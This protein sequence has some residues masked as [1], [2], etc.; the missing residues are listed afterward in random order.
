MGLW[1]WVCITRYWG[2]GPGPKGLW[3]KKGRQNERMAKERSIKRKK[4]TTNE[5]KK[6]QRKKGKINTE[7]KERK[8]E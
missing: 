8:N 5:R 6:K 2:L 7:K 4:C 3:K 1:I